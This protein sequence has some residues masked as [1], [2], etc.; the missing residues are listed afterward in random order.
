M[1]INPL[2]HTILCYGDSN[3]HG[4]RS[5]DVERGRLPADQRW[6]G[7]LQ[8]LLGDGYHVIEEGLGGRTTDLDYADRVGRNGRNYLI[9]CLHSHEPVDVVVL[10]LGTNDTKAQFA[11]S[12][13]EI[14]AALDGLLDDIAQQ[15]LTR[16]GEPPR[17]IVISPIHVDDTTSCFA[18]LNGAVYGPDAAPKSRRLAGE[19]RPVAQKHGA[20]FL[21]AATVAEPGDDGVHLSLPSH[22]RLAEL[23][24]AAIGQVTSDS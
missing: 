1:M 5:E 6:T 18:E 22:D 19:I 4:Q 20:V 7:R 3:T 8:A 9:P 17:T 11:R 2:A 16:S 13:P 15:G 14:A 10:M 23:V 21:D 12:A 24:A